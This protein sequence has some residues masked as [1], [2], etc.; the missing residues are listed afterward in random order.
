MNE[1]PNI[2][3]VSVDSLRA[4]HCGH[5]DGTH[6][7]TPTLDS[8][9]AG[10][11]SF[12]NAIAPGAQTFSSVPASFTGQQRPGESLESYP[13]D[14]H[15]ERRLAAINAHLGT[16]PSLAERLS[17]CGYDT[18]AV[19]PNPWTSTAVGFD[20][21][22]DEFVDLSNEREVGRL[23]ALLDRVPGLDTDDRAV[24]LA[25]N[26][27]TGSS[28]FSQ[29]EDLYD[30]L[31]A[32][33]SRLTEPY[34]LWVFLLD[35]H[36]PFLCSRR[37]RSEQ[38]LPGMYYSNYRSEAIMRGRDGAQPISPRVQRSLERSYR[39]TVRASDA[40]LD[41]VSTDL[42]ED[43]PVIV[44]H[45]DHGESFGDHGNYGHHHRQLY[46]ENVHVPFVVTNVDRSETVEPPVSTASIHDLTLELAREGA[47]T[48]SN[49]TAS[50]VVSRGEAGVNRAVRGA[51]FKYLETSDE[52]FL[53]DLARDPDERSDV[54]GDFP[55]EC[56][57]SRVVL[58]R[59]EATCAEKTRIQHRA[60]ALAAKQPSPPS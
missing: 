49:Y 47:L 24:E 25:I 18:G 6:S 43:D 5:L 40:F 33:R 41:H 31:L 17:Q 42:D 10:G 19:T 7:L 44:V 13:G 22:F 36:F 14:T 20:R 35:T 58:D 15:W 46:E 52:T 16:H 26:M 2:L 39:D 21:G 51:R 34:F 60:R 37:H 12:Q 8:F 4:D 48:P 38:S 54:S 23:P 53:F 56:E 32:V 45:S 11:V 3:L 28:F 1:Q 27:L 9:A 57:S 30:Q 59:F 55:E 50:A 29:W